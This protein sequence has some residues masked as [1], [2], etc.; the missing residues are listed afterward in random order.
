MRTQNR[1]EMSFE[2]IL[3]HLYGALVDPGRFE[4][5]ANG[6]QVR[7]RSNLLAIQ[8]DDGSHRHSVRRHF[9]DT[10]APRDAEFDGEQV[11]Q[12]LL[13]G[14][15]TLLRDGVL[16]AT[17]LFRRGELERTSFYRNVLVPMDVHYSVGVLLGRQ[18][19][20]FVGLSVS[21]HRSAKPFDEADLDLLRALRPHLATVHI[22][23]ERLLYSPWVGRQDEFESVAIYLLD[24][25]GRMLHANLAARRMLERAG[26][27]FMLREGRLEACDRRDRDHLAAAVLNGARSGSRWLAHDT[28]GHPCVIV[29]SHPV[30]IGEFQRHFLLAPP[31]VALRVRP[32]GE[33]CATDRRELLQTVFGLTRAEVVLAC[34]L[35]DCNSLARCRE[36]LGKSHETLRTQLKGLFAK[37]GTSLQAELIRRLQAASHA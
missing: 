20:R 24:A 13:H 29:R 31:V 32:L 7:L 33:V 3:G 11:N 2:V 5:F 8:C 15:D 28:D 14:A 23:Q 6:L 10:R 4:E 36:R 35:L 37:T 30:Q 26:S 17:R 25:K 9:G 12:Y 34:A 19:D 16:D 1:G 27:C 18:G 22:L 21:R